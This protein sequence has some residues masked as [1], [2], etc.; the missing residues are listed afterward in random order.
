MRAVF[1]LLLA[2]AHPKPGSQRH[3]ATRRVKD[4][5]DVLAVRHHPSARRT[6]A[7]AFASLTSEWQLC[8]ECRHEDSDRPARLA[9]LTSTWHS[10]AIG[11]RLG[12]AAKHG[13]PLRWRLDLE[14]L[15]G[16]FSVRHEAANRLDIL[17]SVRLLVNSIDVAAA[18]YVIDKWPKE[19]VFSGFEVGSKIHAGGDLLPVTNRNPVRRAYAL[20]PYNGRRS[21]DA[22]K[23]AYDQTAVLLAVRGAEPKY[24]DVLR[25]GKV[26]VSEQGHTRWL[27]ERVG[28]QAYVRIKGRPHGLT[29]LI[30]ELM[31]KPPRRN[32]GL[33]VPMIFDTDVVATSTMPSPWR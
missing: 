32:R 26:E 17:T 10:L 5:A 21:L 22:G 29:R 14:S 15:G 28:R 3:L 8:D 19:I 1:T 23:P 6:V 11:L 33:P 13:E 30:D 24:W 27:A 4:R 7:C 25:G 20:R 31:A 16:S 18:R 2:F 9:K 12:G